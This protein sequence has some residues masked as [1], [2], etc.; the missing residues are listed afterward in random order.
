MVDLTTAVQRIGTVAAGIAQLSP[1]EIDFGGTVGDCALTFDPA[2]HA[3]APLL[4]IGFCVGPR[5]CPH[6]LTACVPK[7]YDRPATTNV[8]ELAEVFAR[9]G[10]HAPAIF[11]R[12]L[13][14]NGHLAP[15]GAR[16][17]VSPLLTSVT[18]S[19]RL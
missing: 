15:P 13:Q 7:S 1:N 4:R 17:H 8:L 11:A 3:L 9:F 5:P 12:L 19:H 14:C 6:A 2:S 16:V 10:E 18:V